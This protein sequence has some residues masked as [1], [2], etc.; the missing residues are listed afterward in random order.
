MSFHIS[1]RC[2][3]FY[4]SLPEITSIESLLLPEDKL[5]REERAEDTKN[6]NKDKS[7]GTVVT[8]RKE[9]RNS[10][11]RERN[12]SAPENSTSPS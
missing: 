8:I 12:G 5:T 3:I 10:D 2:D 1:R 11:G 7:R 6:E 9:K 4:V